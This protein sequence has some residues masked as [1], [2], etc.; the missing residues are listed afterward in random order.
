VKNISDEALIELYAKGDDRA[1]DKLM[2][3]Y[4]ESL[5]TYIYYILRNNEATEDFLQ[6]TLI[7]AFVTMRQGRYSEGGKFFAWLRRIAHNLIIDAIRQE[8]IGEVVS[9]DEP[10]VNILNDA[11]LSEGNIENRIVACQIRADIRRLVNHLPAEQ[12][13]VVEMHYYHE[14]SFREIAERTGV[15]VNTSLGR[16]RYALKN[17][18]RIADKNGIIL[19]N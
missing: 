6:E 8:R 4:R 12:K 13:E 16:M 14:L 2:E 10:D 1:F 11:K 7:R 19:T 17:M 5:F 9:C 18:R 15:S 3:R